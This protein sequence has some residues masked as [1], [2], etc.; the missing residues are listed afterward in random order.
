MADIF[1]LSFE[2][3]N[4]R[5]TDAQAG[6]A[7]FAATLGHNVERAGPVLA[8]ELR[9]WLDTVAE[10][11]AKRHGSPWPGGTTE[12]TLSKRSGALVQS[13]KDSVEVTGTKLDD[14]QGRLGSALP[15]AKIH[16]TGGTITAKKSKYLTIPLPAALG[17][18]G[19]P[20]K[21]S[22]KEW[23]NTFIAKPRPV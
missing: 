12:K 4:K 16:E 14:I 6:L 7:A 5:Y 13:I 1:E 15:Y 11:L 18:N 21:K 10:A 8:K 9:D 17:P 20:K 19:V 22:A 2:F 23:D 3:K